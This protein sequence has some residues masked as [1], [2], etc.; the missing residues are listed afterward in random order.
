[1][2]RWLSVLAVLSL[3]TGLMTF[4]VIPTTAI[5]ISRILF[6]CFAAG[7][8]GSLALALLRR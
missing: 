5:G 7:L 2:M 4:G 8:T 1:M 6:F 3:V